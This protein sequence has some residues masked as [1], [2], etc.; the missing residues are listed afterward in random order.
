VGGGRLQTMAS[1]TAMT[2]APYVLLSCAMSIDG[3]IDGTG[4]QR[5]VLSSDEDL[6]RVD[7]ERAGCDAILVGAGTVR[8]DDPRLLVRSAAR[9]QERAR[10]GLPPNPIKVTIASGDLEPSGR[11]FT[12]GDAEKLVYCP[13]PAAQRLRARLGPAATVLDAGDP[14]A[15]DRVLDDLARR[16]VRRL[17]VEGGSTIHT[18]FLAARLA[19]E[20]QLVVAPLLVGEAAAPR[21]VRD[22]VLAQA[23]GTRL[24]LAEARPVGDVVLLRYLLTERARDRHWLRAAIELSRRCPPS[25]AAFSVGAVIVDAGGRLMA[26]GWS[27]EGDPHVHA[28][29]A[30]LARV[31]PGDPRLRTATICSSLEPCSR[32]RSRP[33]TCTEL[34]LAAGIPR[35]VLAMREPDLFVDC[36]GVEELL[37]AGVTVVEL[38]DLAHQVR[39]VNAHLLSR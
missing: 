10:R 31:D 24:V 35:V 2:A 39:A 4:P 8:R 32:R 13:A 12:A 9:R 14:L 30:A 7:A 22:G 17:M 15:L 11:F 37:E 3:C 36:H 18:G 20:L 26:E 29:E 25:P 6:D 19:D 5:L 34:I 21:F 33:R 27:R 38:P 16:G 1:T 23:P 28:E